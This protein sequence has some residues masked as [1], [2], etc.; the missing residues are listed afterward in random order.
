MTE[1]KENNSKLEMAY[2]GDILECLDIAN[3][4]PPT[5]SQSMIIGRL[6]EIP[7]A[8]LR[9]TEKGKRYKVLEVTTNSPEHNDNNEIIFILKE[10]DAK[11]PVQYLAGHILIPTIGKEIMISKKDLSKFKLIKRN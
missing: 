3:D 6:G 2:S 10:I 11:K 4:T 7:F 5:L 8:S 9:Q 1:K